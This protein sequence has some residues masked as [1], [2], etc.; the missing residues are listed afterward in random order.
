MNV[1]GIDISEYQRNP[2]ILRNHEGK[3][4]GRAER[5]YVDGNKL[6]ADAWFDC[7]TQESQETKAMIDAGTLKTAS[8]GFE[9]IEMKERPLEDADVKYTKSRPWIKKINE[10]TK[11][12]MLEFSIVDLPANIYAEIQRGLQKNIDV[13]HLQRQYKKL[14]ELQ[15]DGDDMEEEII[16]EFKVKG[17]KEL[18]TMNRFSKFIAEQGYEIVKAGATI[19]KANLAR[20]DAIIDNATKI[21]ESAVKPDNADD[22]PEEDKDKKLYDLINGIN[23]RFDVI[24]DKLEQFEAYD[25]DEEPEQKETIEFKE[26]INRSKK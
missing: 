8:I 2:V 7:I 15:T 18:E 16:M 3:A 24:E 6:L 25:A 13:T 4:I 12:I 1:K 10:I 11:S 5:I 19:S 20:L 9:P 23:K 22:K 17:E 21:K 26:W 14:T